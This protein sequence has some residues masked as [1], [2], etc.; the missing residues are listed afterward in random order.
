MLKYTDSPQ[1]QGIC[2]RAHSQYGD[3][4]YTTSVEKIQKD[5]K[6]KKTS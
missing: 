4:F 2:A 3:S 6:I 5:K 1:V